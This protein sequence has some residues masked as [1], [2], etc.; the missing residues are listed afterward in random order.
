MFLIIYTLH[1]LNIKNLSSYHF[2]TY[3]LWLAPFSAFSMLL[4]CYILSIKKGRLYFVMSQMAKQFLILIIFSIAIFFFDINLKLTS[5]IIA[6]FIALLFII[7]IESAALMHT[8]KF[9]AKERKSFKLKARTHW[10]QDSV[11]FIIANGLFAITCAIDLYLVEIFHTSETD[12]GYYA[13]ILVI[14]SLLV[15]EIPKATSTAIKSNATTM[16]SNNKLEEL[17]SII[18]SVIFINF[19][20]LAAILSVIIIFSKSIL[21]FFGAGYPSAYLPLIIISLSYFLAG[22]YQPYAI[23]LFYT[24]PTKGVK[25][26]LLQLLTTICLGILFTYLWG[27]LGISITVM[28][29][30]SSATTYKSIAARKELKKLKCK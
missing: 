12:V 23:L 16:I 30:L 2:I 10:M 11:K 14:S 9:Y 6:V 28:I 26:D 29:T 27:L 18:N 21:G 8:L 4:S 20:S 3:T 7:T 5:V 24:N 13:A 22:V 17:N 25:I 15:I 19:L 1:F